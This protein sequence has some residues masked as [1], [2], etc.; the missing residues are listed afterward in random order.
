VTRLKPWKHAIRT[1]CLLSS[2]TLLSTT[3]C[4]AGPSPEAGQ[5]LPPGAEERPPETRQALAAGLAG[6]GADYVPRTR[7]LQDDGSATFTNRLILESSPY[8]LQHAHNPVDW[9]SWGDEAF[10]TARRLGRPVLL[11]IGYSTCHWCHVMEEESFEDLE[12]AAFINANYVAIK[13]DR[14]ERPDI[15]AVY[16]SAVQ[17]LTGGGGW[18]MTTWLTPDRQPFYGGTY[19]PPRDGDR[20]ARA[21]FL[22]VLTELRRIYIEDPDGATQQAARITEQI[23]KRMTPA[24]GEGLPDGAAL[25][26]AYARFGEVFDPVEGGTS[27]APKFPSNLPLRL[28]L[29]QH[30]RT[31]DPAALDMVTL[32]LNKMARSG[33]YDQVGGGFHRYATDAAWLVPHFE[34]M[35]YDNALLTLAY[36]EGYQVTG[37]EA[38]AEVVRD[39]LRYVSREMTED[40]G[41]FYSATDADS[42]VPG[43]KRE[44][45]WF[46]TWTPAE[47]RA[48]LPAE[49]AAVVEAYFGVTE[50]GNFEGRSI[51]H[52]TRT[53]PETAAALGRSA[54]CARA[55]F[56]A[57]RT[58]LYEV[59]RER[60]APALD[61]KVLTSWNGLMISAF[62][63]AG[64]VL[65]DPEYVGRASSAAK[66]VL[67]TMVVE[68]RLRRSYNEGSA[69]HNAY[70]DDYAFLIAGLLDLYEATFDASWLDHA[71][72]L[73][74]QF[75]EHYADTE[76]GG[77]FMTSDDHEALLARQKPSYDGAEPSGNS[78]ALMNLVRLEEFTADAQHGDNA[79]KLMRGFG[80]Q[81]SRFPAS[82]TDMLVAV[83][84]HLAPREVVIVGGT[85][86]QATESLDAF[87]GVVR[88]TFSPNKVL[89]VVPSGGDVEAL[90][91]SVP[92]VAGKVAR[93]GK[94]TA[95]V[96]ERGVCK[97]PTTSVET[98]RRQ[99]E[100]VA[101]P[102]N[103]G[104]A[105]AP[106]TPKKIGG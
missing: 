21:G 42:L 105:G 23:R 77:Y 2:L 83:E 87:L 20:G 18:P 9:H 70:L 104:T 30:R 43:G 99:L 86:A 89:A 1:A 106:R 36:L 15:D 66:F 67:S 84:F 75:D 16:M 59:R 44:E 64:F 61:R 6:R 26:A 78:V 49:Q 50:A 95:Y 40:R 91:T 48:V 10:E 46:F 47:I 5:D 103:G 7:H 58:T 65:N 25:D 79:R 35:L 101:V 12:I 11:S 100:N 88:T 69:R 81:L 14:E 71:V 62:A 3:A 97:L 68:G 39:I 27:G 94:T 37:D 82:V 98:F 96:C 17:M 90:A 28:L 102:A 45:G 73:Q 92:W 24:P 74:G 57:A 80:S 63:R 72:R 8:L 41:G 32:T 54:V 53:L 19:F 85:A 51:L 22:T 38:Y 56:D 52:V 93:D 4:T 60:P 76:H 33:M 55:R 34:K 31:G 29:R 13:V